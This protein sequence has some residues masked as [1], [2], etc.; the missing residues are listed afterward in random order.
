MKWIF[1]W[2]VRFVL[3]NGLEWAELPWQEMILINSKSWVS[4]TW[5]K[6]L[7]LFQSILLSSSALHFV[8][9]L[10]KGNVKRQKFYIY[11][12]VFLKSHILKRSIK[13]YRKYNLVTY[14]IKQLQ[15]HR[16]TILAVCFCSVFFAPQSP[17]CLHFNTQGTL[18]QLLRVWI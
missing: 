11:S 13:N 1:K 2:Y 3:W 10:N 18:R 17:A 5:T 9:T 16:V 4:S 12:E 7:K 14:A 15:T 8:L 6:T